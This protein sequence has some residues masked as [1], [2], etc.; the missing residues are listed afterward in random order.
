MNKKSLGDKGEKYGA[1]YLKNK[2]YEIITCNYRTR[3][4]EID[5]IA[6]DKDTLVFVE[7]K[8]RSGSKYGR[9]VEAITSH[10]IEKIHQVALD[11]IQN[12]YEKEPECRFDVIEILNSNEMEILHIE[13]AF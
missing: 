7:V 13:N 12:N 4:G 5:I 9:G 6:K 11:Y 8:L 10:K 2:G 3:Y 1:E